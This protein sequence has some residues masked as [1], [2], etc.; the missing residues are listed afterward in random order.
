MITNTDITKFNSV[1][2]V[3][4][5]TDFAPYEGLVNRTMLSDSYK[6]SHAIQYPQNTTAMFDYGEARSGKVYDV[7]VFNG[8]QPKLKKYFIKPI[9]QW[10]V[11][12]AYMY[13]QAHGVYFDVKGWDYIVQ[14]LGGNLPVTIKAVAEGSVIPVKNALFTIKSTDKKVFWVASWLETVLM[15]VWYPCNVAT[16]SYYVREMLKEYAEKTMD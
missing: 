16:R 11:D 7:T 4:R 1:S 12:E 2:G 15:T 14:T 9:E 3:A 10:E 13:A 8:M 6:Y 5:I